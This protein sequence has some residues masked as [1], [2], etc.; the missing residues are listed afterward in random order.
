EG[1]QKT[2]I[3]IPRRTA[4]ASHVAAAWAEANNVS[5]KPD[6]DDSEVLQEPAGIGSAGG[7]KTP[8][9]HVGDGYTLY[10]EYRGFIESGD[11]ITADPNKQDLMIEDEIGGRAEDGL[12]LLMTIS[13]LAVHSYFTDDELAGDRVMNRNYSP[14]SSHDSDQH[15]LVMVYGGSGASESVGLPGGTPGQH[16]VINISS[17]DAPGPGEWQTVRDGKAQETTSELVVTVA[18]E[19]LHACGVL[20]H[21]DRDIGWVAWSKGTDAD[22]NAVI[23]EGPFTTKSNGKGH[24][25]TI[26]PHGGHPVHV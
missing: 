20:H 25:D 5:G 3:L 10:E 16:D 19:V 12:E 17:A 24:P 11:H 14:E 26:I 8:N 7:S 18:H 9:K 4:R 1:Q 23:I 13:G 22:G 21:G 6:D 2:E 15:G